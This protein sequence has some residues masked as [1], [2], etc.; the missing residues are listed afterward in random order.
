MASKI[1]DVLNFLAP[2]S[3]I[4]TEEDGV[5][6]AYQWVNKHGNIMVETVNMERLQDG[7]AVITVKEPVYD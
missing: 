2:V 6:D 5:I 4:C 7:T 3:Y 1:I